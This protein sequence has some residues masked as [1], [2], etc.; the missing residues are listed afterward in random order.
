M[1]KDLK[2]HLTRQDIQRTIKCTKRRSMPRVIKE[3]QITMQYHP[4]TIRMVEIGIIETLS[5][6]EHRGATVPLIPR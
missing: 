5:A 4:I 2:R 1:A 3:M 6:N